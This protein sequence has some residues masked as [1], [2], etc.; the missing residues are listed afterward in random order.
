[1]TLQ[2]GELIL[3]GKYRVERL[4][5]RGAFG[6]VYLVTHLLLDAAL[7]IKVLRKD[8]PGMGS[9]QFD[10][11]R[12]R[13]LLEAQLGKRLNQPNVVRVDDCVEED[14]V[15]Y[16]VME[17][18]EGGTL[19]ARLDRN[20]AA[21]QPMAVDEAVRIAAE[22]AAGLAAL[23]DLEAVHRDLKPGN[24]LFDRG[25][26]AKVADLGLAQTPGGN[27]FDSLGGGLRFQ[28]GTP[29]YKSPEQADNAPRLRP[30]SDVY[31]LGV[32]LFEM[33]T[34]RLYDNQR[35]GTRVRALRE[36]VPEWLDDLLA[37]M[38]AEKPATR[39]WDGAEA[40]ELL[41]AGGREQ[42]ASATAEQ[43]EPSRGSPEH[44]ESQDPLPA[45]PA[46]VQQE[47]SPPHT[48]P[49]ARP[50]GPPRWPELGIEPVLVPAGPFIYGEDRPQRGLRRT[51]AVL[52][53]YRIACTPVTNAQYAVF[54][55]ETGRAAPPHW[56]GGQPPPG[57]LDHPVVNVT[58]HDAKAFCD[59]AGVRLPTEAEWE[60]A[61][62]GTAGQR[63]PWGDRWL[64]KACN[65]AEEALRGACSVQDYS[66]GASPYEVEQMAG[67]VWEWCADWA[68]E[69]QTQRALR[70]GSFY[71]SR[72]A[73]ACATRYRHYPEGRA[74]DWGFRV[75][76]PQT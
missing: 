43:Q 62:R 25:G 67:N 36:G 73:M 46:A 28:P 12:D 35:P 2:P 1:M 31:A 4:L 76:I 44:A 21:G 38:L 55:K 29:G 27:T 9:T 40:A 30:P 57:L 72:H 47:D 64:S 18:C 71:F 24:I 66:L 58:W 5:G 49:P 37:R 56:P 45:E 13:F 7:A 48:E 32:V 11:Y 14:G 20:R 33:L 22:V 68:D 53:D 8:A 50:A 23:H 59:W 6:E 51:T 34:N 19:A 63:Y 26:R 65:S 41:R 42:A 70:G 15:L 69:A 75:V 52:P 61:A 60:K 54:V 3:N 39:P 17:F 10:R 74:P 16:L